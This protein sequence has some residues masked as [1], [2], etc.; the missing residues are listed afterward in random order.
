MGDISPGL[1]PERGSNRITRG[2]AVRRSNRLQQPNTQ[3][4]QNTENTN[5][6]HSNVLSNV[7]SNVNNN[8]VNSVNNNIID[9]VNNSGINVRSTDMT[10]TQVFPTGDQMNVEST[11]AE[12]Q[13]I[14]D[15][16]NSLG[17]VTLDENDDSPDDAVEGSRVDEESAD[18]SDCSETEHSQNRAAS[19]RD[20]RRFPRRNQPR[21]NTLSGSYFVN[22]FDINQTE[23]EQSWFD[24]EKRS[25]YDNCSWNENSVKQILC[26]P[27]RFFL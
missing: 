13:E 16:N 6:V 18:S 9:G 14:G 7:N 1:R 26:L 12:N 4:T 3:N 22:L 11:T 17:N 5:S 15:L 27:M 19:N 21:L 20:P 24:T 25:P 8:V 10:D 23:H 2:E